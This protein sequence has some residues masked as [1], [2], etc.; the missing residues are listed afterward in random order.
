MK[1]FNH[2]N[3]LIVR[4]LFPRHIKCISCKNELINPNVYDMCENC[5]SKLE[6]ISSNF[7]QRCGLKFEKDGYGTCLNCS[8]T[9]YHFEQ[10]R[11]SAIFSGNLVDIIHRFKYSKY[12]FLSKPLSYLLYDTLLRQNWTIDLIAYVPLYPK[13]EKDRGYNQSRELATDLSMLIKIPVFHDIVRLKDTPSQTSLTRK[14]REVNINSCFKINNKKAINKLN[15]LLIDDVF[16]TGS[17]TNE[18]SKKLKQA[19]ANKIYVLTIAHGGFIQH[20]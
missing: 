10:A 1:I 17:T 13:R 8:R 7:C 12:K 18:I 6:H 5:Y 2:I 19:G 16:T 15:I 20:I 4:S 9:N 11:A 14:E 3:S